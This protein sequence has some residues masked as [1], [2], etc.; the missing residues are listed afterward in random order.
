MAAIPPAANP[1]VR[2]ETALPVRGGAGDGPD[3]DAGEACVA[4]PSPSVPTRGTS[5]R[6]EC[7][8]EETAAAVVIQRHYRGYA[9]RKKVKRM[10]M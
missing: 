1:S 10:K 9:T 7:T 2:G 8:A 5:L 6:P 3:A 4:K